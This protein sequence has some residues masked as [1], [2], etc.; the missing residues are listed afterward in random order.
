M[1]RIQKKNDVARPISKNACITL[2]T[3][4][5]RYGKL[6][7]E[8]IK[9]DINEYTFDIIVCNEALKEEARQQK[10]QARKQR[11]MPKRRR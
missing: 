8:L 4:G 1:F 7:H 5:K 10:E 2:D 11:M 3:I 6:P 9:L